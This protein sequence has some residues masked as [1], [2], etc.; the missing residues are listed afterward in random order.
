MSLNWGMPRVDRVR[1]EL[2]PVGLR[3]VFLVD[4][5]GR[6]PPE[7]VLVREFEGFEGYVRFP[8]IQIFLPEPQQLVLR[9]RRVEQCS[10]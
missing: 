2:R 4:R 3:R 9:Q 7:L 10:D 1:V 8:V 6:W 5:R